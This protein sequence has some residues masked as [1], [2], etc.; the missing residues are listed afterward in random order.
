ME[1]CV[2]ISYPTGLATI[3]QFCEQVWWSSS[4]LSNG[5]HGLTSIPPPSACNPVHHSVNEDIHVHYTWPRNFTHLWWTLWLAYMGEAI[6]SHLYHPREVS[7]AWCW[8]ITR[9]SSS[10]G[11]V[12]LSLPLGVGLTGVGLVHLSCAWPT[13]KGTPASDTMRRSQLWCRMHEFP[14]WSFT[15]YEGI[16]VT[17]WHTTSWGLSSHLSLIFLF[18]WKVSALT[19]M[20]SP[21]FN[22]MAPIFQL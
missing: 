19:R 14:D 12:L 6:D 10:C 5:I 17:I 16:S 2:P 22:P 20:R 3:F 8:V 4:V 13:C 15:L 9:P 18:P 7:L 11:V 21:G 1:G